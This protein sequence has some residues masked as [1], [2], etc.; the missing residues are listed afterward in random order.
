MCEN[1]MS[2]MLNVYEK[3]K[4]HSL[5]LDLMLIIQRKQIYLSLVKVTASEIKVESYP[6]RRVEMNNGQ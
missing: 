1:F 5:K 2:I 4:M 3:K 6:L